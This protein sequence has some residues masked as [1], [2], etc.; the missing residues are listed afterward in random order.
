VINS[1]LDKIE[2]AY[3]QISVRAQYEAEKSNSKRE[4]K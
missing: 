3:E 1:V 4:A 2:D